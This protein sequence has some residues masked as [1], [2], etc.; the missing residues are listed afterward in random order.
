[1]RAAMATD[2]VSVVIVEKLDRLA[3]DLM[4]QEAAIAD[5]H[6]HGLTLLSVVEPDLMANDATRI[7]MLFP[8]GSVGHLTLFPP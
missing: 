2:G 5:F 3:R 4:V 8:A 7:L 6:K 1:M